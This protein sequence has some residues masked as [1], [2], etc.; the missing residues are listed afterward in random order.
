MFQHITIHEFSMLT[1]SEN[2]SGQ[3]IE[4]PLSSA[5]NITMDTGLQNRVGLTLIGNF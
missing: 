4:M 5:S 1:N 3:F 2:I